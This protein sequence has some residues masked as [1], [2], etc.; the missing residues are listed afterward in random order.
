M[1]IIK[2]FHPILDL[3]GLLGENLGAGG[4]PRGRGGGL[5]PG[6]QDAEECLHLLS[7]HFADVHV[8]SFRIKCLRA[9]SYRVTPNHQKKS[10]NV[11]IGGSVLRPAT[12]MTAVHPHNPFTSECTGLHVFLTSPAPPENSGVTFSLHCCIKI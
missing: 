2:V 3:S 11:S 10:A 8:M 5:S 4:A 7:P 6:A 9:V 1:L 12:S